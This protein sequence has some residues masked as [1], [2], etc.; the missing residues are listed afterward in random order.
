MKDSRLPKLLDTIGFAGSDTQL[1]EQ[2]CTEML[3]EGLEVHDRI[4][5][6]RAQKLCR[7]AAAMLKDA[8]TAI[9]GITEPAQCQKRSVIGTQCG[10]ENGHPGQH[11]YRS[12][13][14]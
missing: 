11:I 7:A 1:A 3:N 13:N 14:P 5:V 9:E 12:G 2:M 10:M 6:A 8:H 4:A